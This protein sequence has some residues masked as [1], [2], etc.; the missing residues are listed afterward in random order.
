MR[1]TL[2]RNPENLKMN[3][4]LVGV[5]GVGK[6]TLGGFAAETLKMSFMDMDLSLEA[7]EETDIDGLVK[8]Y[9]DTGLDHKLILFF[10]KQILN[11][12]HTIFAASAR[13]LSQKFFWAIVKQNAITIHL[14]G[15]PLEVYMRQDMWL[16]ERKITQEEKSEKR[17]K[18]SFYDYYKWLIKYCKKADHTVRIVGNIQTDTET[19]CKAIEKIMSADD[20][21]KKDVSD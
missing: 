15:K 9:G 19:L 6:T 17:I 4:V 11:K 12:D 18:D 8:R 2:L 16:G 13:V 20:T 21:M 7:A 3:F 14:Q 5:A 1:K 10:Q